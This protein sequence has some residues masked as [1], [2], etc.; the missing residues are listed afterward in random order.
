MSESRLPAG[1][2]QAPAIERGSAVN[3]S[4]AS[5]EGIRAAAHEMEQSAA[6][7]RRIA[8]V[9]E[10][11]FDARDR[12]AVPTPPRGSSLIT[13]EVASYR[14]KRVRC[15]GCP[16]RPRCPNVLERKR[17]GKVN[18]CRE[19]RSAEGLTRTRLSRAKRKSES[20]LNGSARKRALPTLKEVR[21]SGC[22]ERPDCAN[23]VK[24]YRVR[25]VNQ[26]WQCLAAQGKTRTQRQRAIKRP[27]CEP[28]VRSVWH[29]GE[30]L[31]RC[32]ASSLSWGTFER[33]GV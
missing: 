3:Y 7:L 31:S 8:D 24:R 22:P 9:L 4:R 20:S 21:C 14:L 5:V 6:R 23:V 32:S 25:K 13:P 10:A 1:S 19:C 17:I 18:K 29:G 11:E 28:K 30:G 15:S 27:T 2:D 26:C 12:E 33:A 16:E